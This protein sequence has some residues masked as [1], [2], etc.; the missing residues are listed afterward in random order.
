MMAR[1]T[2]GRS[3]DGV[4]L[5]ATWQPRGE[6]NRLAKLLPQLQ[7]EYRSIVLVLPPE[8]DPALAAELVTLSQT[9]DGFRVQAVLAA[10]WSHGRDLALQ[11]GLA[12]SAS[13]IQ[14]ADLDRLLRW[15]ETRPE[16]W[17]RTTQAIQTADCLIIGRTPS[18]YA[19]HPRALVE[20]EAISNRVASFLLGREM[21]VSAGTKG[22]SREAAQFLV[23]HKPPGRPFGADAA[24]PVL[25]QRAG[26]QVDYVT[27]DGLDWE[28]ADRF[29]DQAA[30]TQRQQQ[31]AQDYDQDPQNWAHRVKVAMEIVQGGLESTGRSL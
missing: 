18:A 3:P 1:Q 5:A 16:E 12:F 11:E 26:F 17:R 27:V 15:A 20:T 30:D 25:L 29:Q 14:Y 21:D 19:T 22:F 9:Q 13:H 8:E 28:S 6:M 23:T 2:T 4:I 24:W 31:A 7:R 10:D